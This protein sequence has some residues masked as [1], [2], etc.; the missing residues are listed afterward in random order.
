MDAQ[1]F[2]ESPFDDSSVRYSDDAQT[3][4]THFPE[5]GPASELASPEGF[6]WIHDVILELVERLSW[7]DHVGCWYANKL[8][9]DGE[10][11]DVV[12]CVD[13]GDAFDTV[14][15][16]EAIAKGLQGELLTA[17]PSDE[18]M[19]EVCE[20]LQ[21][22]ISMLSKELHW[23]RRAPRPPLVGNMVWTP[24]QIIVDVKRA[25]KM[26]YEG[27]KPGLHEVAFKVAVRPAVERAR[28]I[29]PKLP[30]TTSQSAEVVPTDAGSISVAAKPADDVKQ[31]PFALPPKFYL[32]GWREILDAL[33][34]DNDKT[35]QS[36]V[37][38]AHKTVPGPIIMP[39]KGGQPT[40][41]V[42]HDLL[43]WWNGLDDRYRELAAKRD[44]LHADRSAT[45]ENQFDLGRGEHTETVVTEIAGRVKRRRGSA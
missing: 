41:V 36:R 15:R 19:R 13:W 5:C 10:T 14:N 25:M 2:R 32:S 37:R 7:W 35:N 38:K 40:P 26:A 44:S 4:T 9:E 42:K 8:A 43:D 34:L 3:E 23:V 17:M 27:S 31:P 18:L 1:E 29:T 28:L 45:L 6:Q 22:V 11:V 33:G 24:D 12:E 20:R 21:S 39:T 16:I 30:T